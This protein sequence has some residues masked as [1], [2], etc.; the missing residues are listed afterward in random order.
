MKNSARTERGFT[1][2][3]LLVVIAII[4]ILAAIVLASLALTRS[5]GSD[6][7]V[8]EDLVNARSQGELF[9]TTNG[10]SYNAGTAAT[11]ICDPAGL[12]INTHGPLPALLRLMAI[13]GPPPG[14]TRGV[15]SFILNAASVV[16]IG[17][18]TKNAIGTAGNAVC[19]SSATA[20]AAQVPLKQGGFYCVD[21]TSAGVITAVSLITSTTDYTCS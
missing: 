10:N 21:S 4:G 17:S 20:W 13:A 18:V 9:Y 1:L 16:G 6:A 2:I 11:D 8:K 7:V 5:K 3:E 15:N 19:N 14:T 12:V